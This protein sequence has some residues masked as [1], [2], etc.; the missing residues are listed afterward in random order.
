MHWG[1]WRSSIFLPRLT[2]PDVWL[3]AAV[4]GLVALGIVMV[5]NVSYFQAQELYNDPYALFRKHVIAVV[6]GTGIMLAASRVRPELLERAAAVAFGLCIVAL[7]MVLI[8]GIGA[9]RGGAQRWIC[10]TGFCVQPSEFTKLAVVMYLART[11]SR[12]RARIREFAQGFL[13][14]LISVGLV[15]VLVLLQP[16]FGTAALLGAVLWCMLF[17]GGARPLHLAS[18]TAAG[19]MLLTVGIM[20]SGYRMRR[21][22]AYLDPWANCQDSAFQLC[23]S[24]IAFGSGGVSGVGLGQS[25]QKMFFLPE[26]HTDFIFAVVGE[27]LGLIGVVVVLTLF[28]VVALRG[29]RVAARHPDGFASLLA[30]GLTLVVVL[31]AVVNVAVVM[32]LLPTKGLALPFLSYGGSALTGALLQI[33]IVAALSRMTG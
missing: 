29:W 1:R 30:F 16:D 2:Q 4:A 33:G 5:F 17:V 32:G 21:F 23:Q 19:G 12:S 20:F 10:T 25:R 13:P 18:L 7:I 8:P 14:P 28:G 31:G 11:I 15:T 26:A 22:T 6:L 24:L 27:E 3:L 9:K